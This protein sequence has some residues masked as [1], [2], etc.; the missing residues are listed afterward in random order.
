MVNFDPVTK[1]I[2][3]PTKEELMNYRVIV[4]TL[5]TGGR[6]VLSVVLLIYT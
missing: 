1:E 4:T 5:V 3:Y 6:L 2:F